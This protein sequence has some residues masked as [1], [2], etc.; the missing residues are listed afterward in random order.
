MVSVKQFARNLFSLVS[1]YP[2]SLISGT[3]LIT[4]FFAWQIPKL[5]LD[6]SLKAM[7]PT[8]HP[9]IKSMEKGD[10]LF[11]GLA[12]IIVAVES[13]SLLY[14]NT[15]RKLNA[16]QD[17]LSAVP[18]ILTVT[19]IFNF[20]NIVT[21]EDGF[22]VDP[23]IASYPETQ[24]EVDDLI[25]S[26]GSNDKIM[27][28]LVSS[29]FRMMSIY[30]QVSSSMN[31]DEH[32][33]T[34]EIVRIVE[35]FPGSENIYY[36]G[37]PITRSEVMSLMGTDLKTLMP[38]SLIL[39]VFFLTFSF[40][41]WLGV[42]LPFYVVVLSSIWTFGLMGALGMT[43]PFT[44]ILIPIMLIAIANDYGIHIVSHYFEY[45]RQEPETNRPKVIRKTIRTLAIPISL[46]GVTTIVGFMGLLGH[47]LPKVR[48][49][50]LLTSFGI[51]VSFILSVTLIP[52]VL[53]VTRRPTYLFESTSLEGMNTL[54]HGW[55]N[56]FMNYRKPFLVVV[57]ILLAVM[58][59]GIKDVTV[60][61]NPNH[62]FRED[63]RVRVHNE[64]MAKNFGGINQF[65]I[66]IEGDC[67]DPEVLNSIAM[68]TEHLK[69]QP[70]VSGVTSILDPI[71]EIHYS[72]VPEDRETGGIPDDFELM[73]QYLF[74]YSMAGNEESLDLF[75]D[76]VDEP[77]YTQI[78]IR[79]QTVHTLQ[80]ARLIDDTE[81]FIK[82][83]FYDLGK[84]E[85]TGPSAIYAILS[86]MIVKGQMI[87]M[88]I[89]LFVIFIIMTIVFRSLMGGIMA[90][91]PLLLSIIFVFGFMGYAGIE[92]NIATA[93]L[94]SIMI[95]V[96]VDYTVH[97][98]WHLREHIREGL[99]FR[100][101]ME[102]TLKI[103]GKGI[104]FNAGSVIIGFSVLMM[105]I[106]VPVSFFGVLIILSITMCLFGA[107]AVLPALL[108]IV[109][110]DFLHK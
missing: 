7:V 87:S 68:L 26:L 70:H 21:T 15:L 24:E 105:S 38:Y 63:A 4:L 54:L 20:P 31:Y 32:S 82:A 42:F 65:S 33:L 2:R 50:A 56:F 53:S 80:V 74:L 67:R 69:N 8:N 45:I 102:L 77:T 3:L 89:S 59:Y 47:V 28:N 101:A 25:Q 91:F 13:D 37:M 12:F 40:R 106:F 19:S 51:G 35:S 29:D 90:V 49:L 27:G 71:K 79:L 61:A 94:S 62:Y 75:V 110:P 16:L 48:E 52:A 104:V 64:V 100:D 5:E 85:I 44:G 18:N 66:L 99:S 86:T 76:D 23:L 41:S 9:Y 14:G 17:S 11:G 60:D 36:S 72:F 88:F 109:D 103:S 34:E 107:M 81:D 83:N 92:L 22:R 96:G 1:K 10:E 46:A 58:A 30:M 93:M 97:F 78:L 95:G 43:L 6:P 57:V 98:I 108:R 84:I 55:G 39:M 73:A